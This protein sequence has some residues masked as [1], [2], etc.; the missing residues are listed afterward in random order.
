MP[1]PDKH[2]WIAIPNHFQRKT[3]SGQNETL[4]DSL[5]DQLVMPALYHSSNFSLSIHQPFSRMGWNL[6]RFGGNIVVLFEMIVPVHN[7]YYT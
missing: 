4:Q 7:I 6:K 2:P 5:S 3:G 1:I